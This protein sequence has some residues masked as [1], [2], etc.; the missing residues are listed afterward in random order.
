LSL[1]EELRQARSSPATAFHEFK[2]DFKPG[3]SRV[4]SFVEGHEDVV[5][6]GHFVRAFVPDEARIRFYRCGSKRKVYDTFAL[7]EGQHPGLATALFFVDRDYSDF[8]P[9]VVPTDTRIFVTRLY[10]IE[11]Y[12]ACTTI[13]RRALVDLVQV[14]GVVLDREPLV[15]KYD[16][17]L[18]SLQRSLIALSA[19]I[20]AMRE[21]GLKPN[22]ANIK[23]ENVVALSKNDLVVAPRRC[24]RRTDY[25]AR[26]T[27]V[28]VPEGS[29]K[30]V[31][32][33][34]RRLDTEPPKQVTR[35]KFET[36]HL[37]EFLRTAVEM[38]RTVA[39]EGGGS[40][41]QRTVLHPENLISVL[42]AHVPSP[43]ELNEFLTLH[44]GPAAAP[45][46]VYPAPA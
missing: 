17:S 19:W 32:R 11:N 16:E 46:D 42:I 24:Q 28:T 43:R 18:V 39:A 22:A 35:G 33:W 7:V 30:H 31:L 27:G 45:Q 40:A 36:W 26:V 5:F 34:S 13:C 3:S 23:L 2:L 44:L 25:L 15:S 21:L 12:V 1:I 10:S 20:L 41:S 29:W 6:Y 37:L 38:M 9:E 4:Y 8:F 14:S